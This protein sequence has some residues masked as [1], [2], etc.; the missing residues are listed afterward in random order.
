MSTLN[1]I[2]I[3]AITTLVVRKIINFLDS[4]N[5]CKN[6]QNYKPKNNKK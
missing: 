3:S 4:F 6:C 5:K 2:L 1:I